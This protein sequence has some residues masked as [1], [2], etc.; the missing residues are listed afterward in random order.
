MTSSKFNPSDSLKTRALITLSLLF[1]TRLGV[2]IPVPGIDNGAFLQNIDGNATLRFLNVF[3][4][5]A[6]SNLGIFAIGIVPYINASIVMQLLT[7]IVPNF[8]RLQKEE[9]EIGRRKITQYTRYLTFAGAFTQSFF[10]S[11][12]I[13][14][15][16]FN[17]NTGVLLDITLTL[18]AGSLILMWIAELITEEGIGNGTSLLICLN[19]TSGFPKIAQEATTL[20]QTTDSIF[21]VLLVFGSFVLVLLSVVIIQSGTRRISLV[22]ARQ[23]MYQE[24]K[25]RNFLPFRVNQSGIMPII[26]AS[27][28]L[29][30]PT[31]ASQYVSNEQIK[32][33]LL[34]F[35]PTSPN[36]GLYL[37]IYFSAIFIFN[38]F[39]TSII[40]NPSDVS[41]NLKKMASTIKNVRPGQETEKFLQMTIE[42][43]TILGS[44][45]LITISIIP[46]VVQNLTKVSLLNSI[47]ST[48]L[49]ILV[50]TSIEVI[51]QIRT[52][53]ISKSYKEML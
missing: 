27:T 46:T 44:I 11:N 52:F 47:A 30:I 19:I 38:T 22:S 50:G 9:G 24:D 26:F 35:S 45:F 4:G 34:L 12:Y 51:K 31:Q 28:F 18:T 49:I 40:L 17:W 25:S 8:E 10:A 15:Y 42:N 53:E 3:S 7:T 20:V 37:S 43:L 14:P 16:V 36:Q 41:K 21:K 13:R 29:I 23:L 32:N 5:G 39:Y 6:I 2:Y 1:F 48:S 33:F